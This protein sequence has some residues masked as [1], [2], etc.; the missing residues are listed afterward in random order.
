MKQQNKNK[1]LNMKDIDFEELD[2]AVNRFLGGSNKS[3]VKPDQ[4][5]ITQEDLKLQN[6]DSIKDASKF[7]NAASVKPRSGRFMDIMPASPRPTVG[8]NNQ[9][10]VKPLRYTAKVERPA[11]L[12][13]DFKEINSVHRHIDNT[14]G[15]Q[16]T[17]DSSEHINYEKPVLESVEIEN[18][19]SP[20]AEVLDGSETNFDVPSDEIKTDT[21]ENN[22][23][24]R[25]DNN[26][27]EP[28]LHSEKPE[29]TTLTDE[30]I[31]PSEPGVMNIDDSDDDLNIFGVSLAENVSSEG[32]YNAENNNNKV[33]GTEKDLKIENKTRPA[34]ETPLTTPF[35][36][37]ARVEK[38]P[39]GYGMQENSDNFESKLV[40]NSVH[41]D[42]TK[43]DKTTLTPIL[44]RDEYASPV[45]HSKKK[46]GWFAFFAIICIIAIGAGLGALA[47]YFLMA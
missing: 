19:P 28:I 4:T 41:G 16:D 32:Q 18:I 8:R 7:H 45:K 43:E 9:E 6:H 30:I 22:D 11:T 34:E 24:S 33:L 23:D 1:G 42:T 40:N 46:T 27:T 13:D 35:L 17:L 10:P 47:W 29:D 37:N 31:L 26:I 2:K 5:D 39:L 3:T 44:N 38:R 25:S 20:S 12:M 21:L 36:P 14:E 15:I